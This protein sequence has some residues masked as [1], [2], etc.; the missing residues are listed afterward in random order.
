MLYTKDNFDKIPYAK[1][2]D[3]LLCISKW[4][5]T[6]CVHAV[7]IDPQG[8]AALLFDDILDDDT[9]R[10]V[11]SEFINKNWGVESYKDIELN[12]YNTHL[13]NYDRGTTQI[14]TPEGFDI[15]S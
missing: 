14:F 8:G 12:P 15:R 5:A 13:F 9:I 10:L 2:H 7:Y 1:L 4:D 3:S 6:K 11:L